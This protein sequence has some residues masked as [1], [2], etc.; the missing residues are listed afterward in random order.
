M[1]KIIAI[2]A[3]VFMVSCG[4]AIAGNGHGPGDG[5]GTGDQSGQ[6]GPGDCTAE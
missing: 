1:K 2:I 4:A 3:I 6:H 5:T